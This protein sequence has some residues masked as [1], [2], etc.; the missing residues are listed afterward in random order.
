MPDGSH[1]WGVLNLTRPKKALSPSTDGS[2]SL[3]SRTR[4]GNHV[5]EIGRAK[6]LFLETLEGA[7]VDP[8]SD[9][10]CSEINLV[11]FGHEL[12]LGFGILQI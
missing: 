2:S 11:S 3:H 8:A 7:E 10:H 5:S 1:R 6:D 9:R 4:P 12:G